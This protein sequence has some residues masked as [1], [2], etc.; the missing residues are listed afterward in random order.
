MS[1][2]LLPAGSNHAELVVHRRVQV[3]MVLHLDRFWSC[4]EKLSTRHL[5]G[6]GPT[7]NEGY[8]GRWRFQGKS[9]TPRHGR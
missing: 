3:D 5:L 4:M 6:L 7:V 2:S 8:A 1:W 9:K